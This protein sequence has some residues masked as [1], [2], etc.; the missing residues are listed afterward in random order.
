MDGGPGG[1][2][3][4]RQHRRGRGLPGAH[5]KQGRRDEIQTLHL[6]VP[7]GH[8]HADMRVDG[9]LFRRW[10]HASTGHCRA[11]TRG[12]GRTPLQQS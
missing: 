10:T 12:R 1:Q 11:R 7:W 9:P 5:T 8:L 4:A 6:H 3:K 2:A